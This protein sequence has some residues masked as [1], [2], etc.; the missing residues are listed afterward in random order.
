M[1]TDAK[2]REPRRAVNVR[3]PEP[4]AEWLRREAF[5]QRCGQGELVERGLSLL[6]DTQ[7]P[8]WSWERG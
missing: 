3:L 6:R 7:S 8:D 2:E 1:S 4:V 5:E